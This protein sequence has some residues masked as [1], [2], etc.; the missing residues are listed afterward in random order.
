[1]MTSICFQNTPKVPS[2]TTSMGREAK[3]DDGYTF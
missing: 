2:I 1:M 3:I